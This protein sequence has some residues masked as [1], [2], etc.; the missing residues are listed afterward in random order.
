MTHYLRITS[1]IFLA[2]GSLPACAGHGKA[3]YSNSAFNHS[4][5]DYAKVL[6]VRPVTEIVQIQ[7]EQQVCREEPV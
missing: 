2:I 7:E 4:Q 3:I 6:Q 1:L 5:Y